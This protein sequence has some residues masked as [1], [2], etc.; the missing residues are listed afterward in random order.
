MSLL[1]LTQQF[2]KLKLTQKRKE[3]NT[4]WCQALD[5]SWYTLIEHEK[6]AMGLKR[7]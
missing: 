6:N 1:N 7:G 2:H 5:L 4:Q 3:N